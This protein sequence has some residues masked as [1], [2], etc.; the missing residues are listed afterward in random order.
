MPISYLAF[1]VLL[2]IQFLVICALIWGQ[3]SCDRCGYPKWTHGKE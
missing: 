3:D 2:V 1:G